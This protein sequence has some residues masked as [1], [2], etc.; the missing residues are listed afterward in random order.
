MGLPEPQRFFIED[1]CARWGVTPEYILEIG[2]SGE[3]IIW[4]DF[5]RKFAVP[6]GYF[7]LSEKE[8]D[9]KYPDIAEPF[10]LPIRFLFDKIESKPASWELSL[11]RINHGEATVQKVH[12][13][14]GSK[15][16]EITV[17]TGTPEP[18]PFSLKNLF[19]KLEDVKAFET[20]H[21]IDVNQDNEPS[22]P[23]QLP[24]KRERTLLKVTGALLSMKYQA[25]NHFKTNGEVN[26]TAVA[27]QFDIDLAAAG[28]TDD[29][30]K[31][32]TIR[33]T[34]IKQALEAIAEN[35]KE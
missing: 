5:N 32:D 17:S 29:G 33:K 2:I 13:L 11:L 15:N 19:V 34:I 30:L 18:F 27:D 25:H 24:A 4:A 16:T 9:K 14:H 6:Q 23:A 1:L 3:L 22:P 28:F 20:K 21:G 8:R 31:P 35:R 7:L 12:C 10:M 26:A